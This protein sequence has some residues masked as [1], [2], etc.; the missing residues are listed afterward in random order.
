MSS[1]LFAKA[2]L[3][4]LAVCSVSLAQDARWWSDDVQD[5]LTKA[6]DNRKE[7]EQTLV[8]APK[9]Q[10]PGIAFLIA[11]MPEKDRTTLKADFLLKNLELAYQARDKMPWG[12]TVPEEIF[13]N[14]VLPYANV[15]ETREP[16]RQEMMDLCL[17]MVKDSKTLSEAAQKLNVEVFKKL[18]VGYSTKRKRP[19]QSPSESTKIGMASC[20]GLSILLVD[21]CRSV[22]IPA[23]LVGTAKWATKPGNH[24]WVEIWD[25]GWHFTGACEQDP[26]GLNRGWFTGDA[27]QAKKDSAESAIYA[28]SFRRTGTSFPLVWAPGL[29]DVY[30]ENVT[31]RYTRGK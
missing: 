19:D 17:P 22:G 27:A 9:E 6:K 1:R 12:K 30:A 31:E 21:A 8:A 2:A 20:T 15:T 28:V 16:W 23:R 5:A 13:L 3:V 14:D 11:H 29:K 24:T 26:A 18:K 10:R 25:K 4:W 7:L